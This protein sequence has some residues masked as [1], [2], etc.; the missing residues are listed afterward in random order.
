MW[1]TEYL[2]KQAMR[3]AEFLKNRETWV[4]KRGDLY[5]V[6]LNPYRGSEQGGCRPVLVVQ[7]KAGNY[8]AT[9]L[10]VAPLTSR[11]LKKNDLPTHYYLQWAYGLPHPS[12]VLLEQM[13]TIDKVRVKY[14][15][16][17]VLKSDM[18]NIDDMIRTSL[19]LYLTRDNN[20]ES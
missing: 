8:H 14:Y 20:G 2:E 17:H 13:R 10:I 15:M 3:K 19:G 12:L 7:N 1:K 11:V 5:F 9:T 16:G 18:K 4:Y 6:T